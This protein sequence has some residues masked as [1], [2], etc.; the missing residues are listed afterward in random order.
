[1]TFLTS[2]YVH[3]NRFTFILFLFRGRKIPRSV[4]QWPPPL[5]ACQRSSFHS[6][7]KTSSLRCQ[8]RHNPRILLALPGRWVGE[9]IH[10]LNLLVSSIRGFTDYE[11]YVVTISLSFDELPLE[12]YCGFRNQCFVLFLCCAFHGMGIS[13]QGGS[14]GTSSSSLWVV[15]DQR[16]LSS[17]SKFFYRPSVCPHI[18]SSRH[19]LAFSSTFLRK[20][21]MIAFG[22]AF[23]HVIVTLMVLLNT[24]ASVS[25]GLSFSYITSLYLH[26]LDIV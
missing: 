26:C 7:E 21:Y 8:R 18:L 2:D 13:T 4:F 20:S 12:F 15:E 10:I 16:T 24:F 14:S 3:S 5:L 1:M 19:S 23:L 22:T 6:C 25:S 11:E 9:K 17:S